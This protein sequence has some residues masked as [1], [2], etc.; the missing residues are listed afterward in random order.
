VLLSSGDE[1]WTVPARTEPFTAESLEPISPADRGPYPLAV[2]VE[3]RFPPPPEIAPE[4][5]E[6]SSAPPALKRAPGKL[7]LIGAA[8]PFQE[9]FIKAG[10]H[11]NFFLNCVD[12]LSLGE[13]LIQIR[14]KRPVDRSLGNVSASAR[15]GWRV[16]GV[17]LL[18]VL[19]ALWGGLKIFAGAKAKRNYLESLQTL[20]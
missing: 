20:P 16:A 19:I 9:T 10:G 11:M 1:S 7:I 14:A 2:L 12:A 3:G 4:A 15:I 5:G 13:D 8:V 6:E 17:L 18:P